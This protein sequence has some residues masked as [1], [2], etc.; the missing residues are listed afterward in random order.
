MGKNKRSLTFIYTTLL[1]IAGCIEYEENLIIKQ[2]G[3]GI[4]TMTYGMPL[5]MV[6]RDTSFT[7]EK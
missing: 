1:L 2:D 3:S 6:E 5:E 7:A 4:I